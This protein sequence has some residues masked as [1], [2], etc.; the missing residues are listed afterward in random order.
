MFVRYLPVIMRYFFIVP[1][2]ALLLVSCTSIKNIIYLQSTG[3][4]D[5]VSFFTNEQPDYIIR[6]GDILFVRILSIN[7]EIAELYNVANNAN[8]TWNSE[9]SLF[10][11]GFS[12]DRDGFIDLPTLGLVKVVNM[13]LEE[14]Q[15]T[16]Q[17]KV[18]ESLKDATTIV[19]LVSYRITVLGEVRSPGV[20]TINKSQAT[21]FE[22]IGMAGDI[23]PM[24]NKKN[25][26]LLRPGE[27]GVQT[28]R[29]DLTDKNLLTSDFYYLHPNDVL[30]IEPVKGVALQANVPSISV[31]L[32]LL[33]S[34]LSILTIMRYYM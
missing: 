2:L 18:D 6:T 4:E 34:L 21:I 16:I 9:T 5:T 22:A 19:K 14:A 31:V 27:K 3:S 24:G 20:K 23:L 29:I 25:V 26:L 30:Y 1:A 13:T 8:Y 15:K 28:H 11:N 12:V 32:S 10:V 17:L 33:A 7:N